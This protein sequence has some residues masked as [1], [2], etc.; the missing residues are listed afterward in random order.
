MSADMSTYTVAKHVRMLQASQMWG[1]T[2]GEVGGG[3]D[4]GGAMRELDNRPG[5]NPDIP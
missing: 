1:Y 2:T 5:N 4:V 3:G